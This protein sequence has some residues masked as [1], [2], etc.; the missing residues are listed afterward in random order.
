MWRFEPKSLSEKDIGLFYTAVNLDTSKYSG[1]DN[2]CSN[3]SFFTQTVGHF[4]KSP[5]SYFLKLPSDEFSIVSEA[6]G[7]AMIGHFEDNF[8][9]NLPRVMEQ[10]IVSEWAESIIDRCNLEDKDVIG[11]DK[12][13]I[14]PIYSRELEV[15]C[16]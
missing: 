11:G 1:Y 13:R 12:Y 6:F 3:S 10:G 8:F 7:Y 16:K 9:E 4:D 14:G 5:M 2:Y 15:S